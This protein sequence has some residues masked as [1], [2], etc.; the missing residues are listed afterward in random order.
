MK[1]LHQTPTERRR[2][3]RNKIYRFL[4]TQP[5]GC[6]KQEI[7]DALSLS[8]PTVHQNVS[9]LF[10]AEL[11]RP[12]GINE[13]KGGRPALRLT[14]A[15]NVRFALGISVSNKHIRVLAANLRLEEV[16]YQKYEHPHFQ[17]L[18]E[19]GAVLS[20]TVEKFMQRFGLNPEKLLGVGIALPAVLNADLTQLI[21]A[22]TLHLRNV[23]LRPLIE[24]FTVPVAVGND[25]VSGGYAEWFARKKRGSLVYLSLEDGVGGAIMVNNSAYIG[26][27]GRSGEFGHI[28]VHPGG[29]RCRCGQQGCLEAY[30]SSARLS[31]DLGITVDQF[32]DELHRGNLSYQILWKDYLSHLAAALSMIRMAF[33][34]DIVLGGYLSQYLQPYLEDLRA[35]AAARDPFDADGTFIHLCKYPKHAAPLGAA[36]QF[37]DRFLKEL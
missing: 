35:L 27:H 26:D 10:Q 33:D 34:C 7:A 11:I 3:T 14:V 8:L 1:E 31:S 25:A 30:C 32:F 6:S 20:E 13:S 29:L 16:A 2:I 9:E 21:N 5:E 12:A 37:I 17:T 36:L 28:C 4:Y 23:E 15:E 19:M 22:P 18:A 24:A